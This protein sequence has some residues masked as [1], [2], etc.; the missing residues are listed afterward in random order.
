MK[1]PSQHCGAK[2]PVLQEELGARLAGGMAKE[3]E[4]M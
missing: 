1:H 4:W 2:L 3:R